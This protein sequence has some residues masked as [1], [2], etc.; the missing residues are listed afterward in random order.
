MPGLETHVSSDETDLARDTSLG[1]L[2]EAA[3]DSES[4]RVEMAEVGTI[5][6]GMTISLLAGL[7]IWLAIVIAIVVIF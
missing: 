5:F 6:T 2:D 7:V 4:A 3:L 1:D